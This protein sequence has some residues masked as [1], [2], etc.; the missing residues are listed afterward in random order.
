MHFMFSGIFIPDFG[1][2]NRSTQP[3]LHHH[4]TQRIV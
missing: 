4:K 2:Y 3:F 1:I